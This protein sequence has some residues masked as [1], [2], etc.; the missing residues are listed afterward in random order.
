MSERTSKIPAWKKRVKEKLSSYEWRKLRE[1]I[2]LKEEMESLQMEFRK[3]LADFVTGA[4]SFVAALVWR[5]AIKSTLDRIMMGVSIPIHQE[6]I[7]SLV[8]ALLISM[9]SIFG[10]IMVSKILRPEEKKKN[11]KI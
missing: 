8:T 4:F 3:H 11:D 2:R 10:I 7:L 1:E 6:W 9:L 5:D